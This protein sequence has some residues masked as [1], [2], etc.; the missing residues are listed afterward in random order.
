MLGW[1]GAGW[2]LGRR[3]GRRVAGKS[4]HKAQ[5][6]GV[7]KVK[8]EGAV[9]LFGESFKSIHNRRLAAEQAKGRLR[10]QRPWV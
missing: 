1:V 9:P 10:G 3:S 5:V 8:E 2:V 6:S 7:R 4:Q